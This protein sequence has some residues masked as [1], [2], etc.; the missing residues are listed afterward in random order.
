M[1]ETRS[2]GTE[3]R[4]SL[5]R[6]MVANVLEI[7]QTRLQLAATE[8]EIERLHLARLALQASFTFL[9]VG[10]GAMLAM[11]AIVLACQP[12]WRPWVAG[13]FSGLCFGAAAW[14]WRCWRLTGARKPALLASTIAEFTADQHMLRNP[15]P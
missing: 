6:D 1:A 11:G 3:T 9:F 8:L 14:A 15:G 13:A 5:V 4:A 7:G 10:L 12:A 2:V